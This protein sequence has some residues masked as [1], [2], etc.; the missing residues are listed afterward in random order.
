MT[1]VRRAY[2]VRWT[3]RWPYGLSVLQ[4]AIR[5]ASVGYATASP[6]NLFVWGKG[7]QMISTD[8]IPA[9]VVVIG[10]AQIIIG[11]CRKGILFDDGPDQDRRTIIN[12]DLE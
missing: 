11:G 9:D 10:R 5:V 1:I 4:H 12:D 3:K 8:Y 6:T 7:T 2:P